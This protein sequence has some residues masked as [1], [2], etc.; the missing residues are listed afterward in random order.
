MIPTVALKKKS[1]VTKQRRLRQR[2]SCL[3]W[4]VEKASRNVTLEVRFGAEKESGSHTLQESVI[5]IAETL[6]TWPASEQGGQSVKMRY[7]TSAQTR[8]C[9]ATGKSLDFYEWGE[10]PMEGLK[11]R[12]DTI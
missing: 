10:K 1:K 3:R 5:W 4:E 2:G 12:D 6:K 11:L 8:F 7:E 9:G